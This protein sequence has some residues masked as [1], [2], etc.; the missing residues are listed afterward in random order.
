MSR[1][2]FIA[3]TK[4]K[5]DSYGL[6]T[7][8]L[9]QLTDGRYMFHKEKLVFVNSP[10]FEVMMNDPACEALTPDQYKELLPRNPYE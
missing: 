10:E 1:L 3:A 5:M 8:T 2:V 6:N 7:D 4:E 9:R